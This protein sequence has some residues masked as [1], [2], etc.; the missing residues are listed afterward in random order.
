MEL[1][2]S[3]EANALTSVERTLLTYLLKAEGLLK[4]KAALRAATE[5]F[6]VGLETQLRILSNTS[7]SSET[8][9]SES[10]EPATR[11]GQLPEGSCGL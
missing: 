7:S 4:L 5:Q 10:D 8:T 9:P 2:E 11:S 3:A 1:V 6:S